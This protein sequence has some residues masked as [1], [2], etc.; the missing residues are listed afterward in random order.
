MVTEMAS[1]TISLASSQMDENSFYGDVAPQTPFSVETSDFSS[2]FITSVKGW[3]SQMLSSAGQNKPVPRPKGEE[4]LKRRNNKRSRSPPR[5][6]Y[7]TRSTVAP[8]QRSF[9]V[10]P[11]NRT[12]KKY[13]NKVARKEAVEVYVICSLRFT[14]VVNTEV[15]NTF[16]W[17]KRAVVNLHPLCSFLK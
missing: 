2:P 15:S 1:P 3:N 8:I 14:M 9:S 12:L 10:L 17:L 7:M 4:V 6:T 11:S 5:S 13:R 16:R